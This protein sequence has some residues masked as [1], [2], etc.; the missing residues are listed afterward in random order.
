MACCAQSRS[1]ASSDRRARGG[2]GTGAIAPGDGVDR[3]HSARGSQSNRGGA[4]IQAS[5][6]RVP[7]EAGRHR[8]GGGE[9][10][11]D[12]RESSAVVEAV[13]RSSRRSRVRSALRW[14]TPAHWSPF[15]S[16]PINGA[17]LARSLRATLSVR[18]TESMV[19]RL[20]EAGKPPA[21]TAPKPVR[22]SHPGCGRAPAL[23]SW[24]ARADRRRGSRGRIEIDFNSEDRA[25]SDLRTTHEPVT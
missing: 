1:F 22:R 7:V 23:R 2:G 11:C 12:D 4:R 6:R 3:K 24:H 16:K 15:R 9:G 8:G 17:C 14:A 10:P 20:V 5:V 13:R 18:E 21:T 19:K 25:H